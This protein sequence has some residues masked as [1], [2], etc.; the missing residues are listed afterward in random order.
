MTTWEPWLDSTVSEIKDVLTVTLLSRK[1][2]SLQVPNGNYKYYLRDRCWRQLTG[3]AR[4]P[5]DPPLKSA[6][7]AQRLKELTD[8]NVTLRRRLDSV[9]DQLYT[10]DLHMRRGRDVRVVPLPPGGGAKTGQSR[11]GPRTRGGGTSR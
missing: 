8:K 6:Q 5:L 1:K 11:S 10:H 2:M 9:D 3:E 7:D 4:I